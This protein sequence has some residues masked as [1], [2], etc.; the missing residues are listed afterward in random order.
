MSHVQEANAGAGRRL[1]V[2]ACANFVRVHNRHLCMS[3]MAE[4]HFSSSSRGKLLLRVCIVLLPFYESVLQ[5]RPGS[6]YDAK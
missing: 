1:R 3:S 5:Q 2:Q 6:G 4:M